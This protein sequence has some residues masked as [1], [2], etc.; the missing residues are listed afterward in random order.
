MS[1]KNAYNFFNHCQA[2][3]KFRK[4]LYQCKNRK[5]LLCKATQEGFFFSNADAASALERM[6]TEAQN[7]DEAILVN[8]LKLWYELQTEG[9]DE[10]PLAVC[11]A[12][13]LRYSCSNYTSQKKAQAE[14]SSE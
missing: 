4:S 9:E 7:E 6:K 11:S 3:Q 14:Q 10:N 12:C 2:N 13:S 1:I 5:E 8:E